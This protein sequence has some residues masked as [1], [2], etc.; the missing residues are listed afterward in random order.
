[1]LTGD[2]SVRVAKSF[3][4]FY[5][6]QTTANNAHILVCVI[7]IIL[8]LSSYFLLAYEIIFTYLRYLCDLLM[9]LCNREVQRM[10]EQILQRQLFT[11]CVYSSI[12][13]CVLCLS[14]QILLV[15]IRPKCTGTAVMTL[16][17]FKSVGALH[18]HFSCLQIW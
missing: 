4:P 5:T 12:L 1:M 13:I 10:M 16:I 9:I 8:Y 6:F 18:A 3:P 17:Q 11:P 14:M 7:Y 15:W 2:P